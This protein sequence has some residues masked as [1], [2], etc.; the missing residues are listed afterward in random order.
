MRAKRLLSAFLIFAVSTTF[1]C[2]DTPDPLAPVQPEFARKIKPP[3]PAPVELLEYYI[4]QDEAGGNFVHIL[5]TGTF[6][7]VNLNVVQDYIFNGIRDDDYSIWYEY[8]TSA[9]LPMGP[10]DLANEGLWAFDE[11]SQAWHIDIPWN[12]ETW[13]R[14]YT[15]PDNPQFDTHFPDFPHSDLDGSGGDPYAFDIR[16]QEEN[17][18]YI[19]GYQPQGIILAGKEEGVAVMFEHGESAFHGDVGTIYSYATFSG[20]PAKDSVFID[21]IIV[22]EGSFTCDVKTIRERIDK[23]RVTRQVSE[24]YG[25]AQVIL[26]TGD[27]EPIPDAWID[28]AL[29]PATDGPQGQPEFLDSF[30][31]THGSESWAAGWGVSTRFEGAQTTLELRLAVPYVYATDLQ[32]EM[33]YDPTLNNDGNGDDWWT[34]DAESIS[35]FNR[36][37]YAIT[38]PFTIDCGK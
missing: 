24:V 29:V 26:S 23:V 34:F 11:A 17:G 38:A 19:Q 35:E 3:P 8:T 31:T 10:E 6:P 21:Q 12:G 9:P 27:G 25:R 20:A 15:L 18:D 28:V 7:L 13:Y 37:P 22:D 30:I 14:D 5:A 32:D 2:T 1:S 16:F 33:V 36:F 4:F